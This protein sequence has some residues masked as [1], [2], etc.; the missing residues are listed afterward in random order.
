MCIEMRKSRC[1]RKVPTSTTDTRVWSVTV[2]KAAMV[3]YLE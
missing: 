2:N 3:P 1:T